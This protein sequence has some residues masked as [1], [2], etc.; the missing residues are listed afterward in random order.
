MAKNFASSTGAFKA[1]TEQSMRALL[2]VPT[3]HLRALLKAAPNVKP[4]LAAALQSLSPEERQALLAG[5]T[6]KE[7]LV[8]E[9]GVAAGVPVRKS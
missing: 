3:Q 6:E 4:L 7:K 9:L 2:T 5:D 8:K 1:N